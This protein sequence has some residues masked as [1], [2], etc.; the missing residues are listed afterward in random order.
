M[1]LGLLM[2][3]LFYLRE[4]PTHKPLTVAGCIVDCTLSQQ[5][6]RYIIKRICFYHSIC[7]YNKRPLFYLCKDRSLYS[8]HLQKVMRI[9]YM[10]LWEILKYLINYVFSKWQISDRSAWNVID[11]LSMI[12][13]VKVCRLAIKSSS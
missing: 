7:E 2:P 11:L 1:L 5:L 4:H 10:Q 6:N 3:P 9:L 8:C 12:T 13:L